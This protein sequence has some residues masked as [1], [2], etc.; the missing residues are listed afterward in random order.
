MIFDLD[1]LADLDLDGHRVVYNAAFAALGL[2][3]HWSVE[4]YQ[5][6]LALSDERQRVTAELRKRCVGTECDVLVDLLV[7]E[8]CATKEMMFEEIILDAGVTPRPG[9]HDLVMD[10]FV[11]H[12]PVSVVTD[13][14]RSWAE[15]LVRQLVG[16]GVVESVVTADD[17][18][19]PDKF[20]HALGELGVGS[21]D[22]LAITG[23]TAGLRAANAAGLATVLI[24]TAAGGNRSAAAVRTGYAGVA[25]PLR[26]ASCRRLHARWWDQHSPSAA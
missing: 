21:H 12:I 10:A 14:R 25:D 11:A 26:L 18:I 2:S 23:S 6:L 3:L 17:L 8:I 4:R 20:S 22:A 15:P 13:G 7:D 19:G 1:A 16:D 5:Q 9:L 24:E